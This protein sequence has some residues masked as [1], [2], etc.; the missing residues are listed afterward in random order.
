MYNVNESNLKSTGWTL[1]WY[2][3]KVLHTVL[4]SGLTQVLNKGLV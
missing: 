4:N 1:N 2:T 3:F